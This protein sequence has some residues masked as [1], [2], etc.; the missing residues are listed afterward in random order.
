MEEHALPATNDNDLLALI[1]AG[2]GV[3]Y[4]TQTRPLSIGTVEA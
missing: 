1:R 2:E 4:T 3:E